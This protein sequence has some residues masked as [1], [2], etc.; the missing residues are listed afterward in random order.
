MVK[1]MEVT[2]LPMPSTLA[3]CFQGDRGGFQM[4]KCNHQHQ[5]AF[6]CHSLM[7][8]KPNQTLQAFVECGW[9]AC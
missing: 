7:R 1:A 6:F 4:K 9:K 3:T 5:S 2:L 8:A